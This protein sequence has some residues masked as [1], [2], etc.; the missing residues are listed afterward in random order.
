MAKQKRHI[1]DF[2]DTADF[3]LVGICT[4]HNGYRLAWGINDKLGL[5]LTQS[6]EPFIITFTKKGVVTH[7]SYSMYEYYEEENRVNYSLVKNKENGKFLIP[8]KPS[9]DY[10]LFIEENDSINLDQLG[11]DLKKVDSILAVF[12]LDTDTL[13][14]TNNIIF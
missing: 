11:I 6:I 2:D 10:F 5:K 8:E 4:H 1:L 12:I 7:Q 9:I 13:P 3:S 14:S